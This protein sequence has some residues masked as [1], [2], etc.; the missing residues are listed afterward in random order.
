MIRYAIEHLPHGL[1]VRGRG[2]PVSDLDGLG[3]IAK[4]HGYEMLDAQIAE[5]IGA[6][7]VFVSAESGKAWRAEIEAGIASCVLHL[8]TGKHRAA[9]RGAWTSPMT[10]CGEQSPCVHGNMSQ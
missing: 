10:S 8:H 6:T 9:L 5:K 3:A 1:V 4:A 7:F 2:V